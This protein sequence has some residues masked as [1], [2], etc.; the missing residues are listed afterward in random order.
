MKVLI[1]RI[2]YDREVT[3]KFGP[4]HRFNAHYDNKI[5]SF[6]SKSKEQTAFIQGE[7]N[8][9]TETENYHN[10]NTYYNIKP[11]KSQG[12][13]NFSRKLK[14]EQARYSGFAMSYAN[15][16]REYL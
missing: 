1:T 3:T 14:Q 4:A 7:E 15:V 9:F 13:S 11:I 2:V 5:G 16:L 6:L 10:G 12:S 8:E